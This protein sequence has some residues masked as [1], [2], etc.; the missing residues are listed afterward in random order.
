MP[1]GASPFPP[2]ADYGFLSD[3][4]TTALDPK[5]EVLC[6]DIAEFGG[7]WFAVTAD[8]KPPA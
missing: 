4:H 3:C 8:G 1:V 7:T 2:I 6:N 5:G